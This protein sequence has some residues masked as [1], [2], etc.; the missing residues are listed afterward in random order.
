MKTTSLSQIVPMKDDIDILLYSS[1]IELSE[2]N[3]Q[4]FGKSNVS[5]YFPGH[6]KQRDKNMQH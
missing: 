3:L 5:F 4:H 1:F 6:A 2:S